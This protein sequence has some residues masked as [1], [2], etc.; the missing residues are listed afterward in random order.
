M[1]IA[2]Y[3]VNFSFKYDG[4]KNVKYYLSKHINTVFDFENIEEERVRKTTS[5]KTVVD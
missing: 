3:C 5:L 1:C 2:G 4:T